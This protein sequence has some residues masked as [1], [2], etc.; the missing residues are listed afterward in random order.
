M[1]ALFRKLFWNSEKNSEKNGNLDALLRSNIRNVRNIAIAVPGC[2]A[3]GLHPSFIR[4]THSAV[5]LPSACPAHNVN[6]VLVHPKG[7]PQLL[8]VAA[9]GYRL[10]F[11]ALRRKSSQ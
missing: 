8:A 9:C 7:I 2:G 3:V 10:L 1:S 6:G 4:F 11:S 5:C